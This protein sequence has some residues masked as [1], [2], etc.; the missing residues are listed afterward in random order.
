MFRKKLICRECP[1]YRKMGSREMQ[2]YLDHMSDIDNAEHSAL[3]RPQAIGRGTIGPSEPGQEGEGLMA[4]K[5]KL[6]EMREGGRNALI[7][8]MREKGVPLPDGGGAY[9]DAPL[10]MGMVKLQLDSSRILCPKEISRIRRRLKDD[11]PQD[12]RGAVALLASI[13]LDDGIHSTRT[14]QLALAAL[15]ISSHASA[16][17]RDA[18]FALGF[19]RE[20]MEGIFGPR[21]L[22]G[23][24]NTFSNPLFIGGSIGAFAFEY[25]LQVPGLAGALFGIAVGTAIFA[26]SSTREE[27]FLSHIKHRVA[28]D[29]ALAMIGDPRRPFLARDREG[30]EKVLDADDLSSAI[31][32]ILGLDVREDR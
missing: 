16:E 6:D 4:S 19:T 13:V 17:S 20:G 22:R 11:D 31:D 9:R 5:A 30:D 27:R 25:C 12:R 24:R 10:D 15:V 1:D 8:L 18:L 23:L 32:G 28:I 2:R 26:G 14:Q 7:A 3:G 29:A 21:A